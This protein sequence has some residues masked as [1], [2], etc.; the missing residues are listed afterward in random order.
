M[1]SHLVLSTLV[2]AIA[3]AAARLLPLTARTRHA[4]LL[5]GLA[6]FA[7]PPAL[8]TAIGFRPTPTAKIGRAHV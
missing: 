8:L 6:K 4:L 3:I 1:I 5:A 2:L 7:I